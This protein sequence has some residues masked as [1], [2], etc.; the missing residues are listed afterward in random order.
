MWFPPPT[1]QDYSDQHPENAAEI[2][3]T[4]AQLKISQGSRD[5]FSMTDV[6]MPTETDSWNDSEAVAD[7]VIF[8]IFAS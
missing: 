4:M 1:I 7:Y 3:L 2:K 6:T 8:K 5:R